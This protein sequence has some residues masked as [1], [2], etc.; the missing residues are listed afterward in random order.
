MAYGILRVKWDNAKRKFDRDWIEVDR[1]GKKYLA[2]TFHEASLLAD[3]LSNNREKLDHDFR[4]K[5]YA[6]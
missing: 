5:E 4:V 3:Q 6:A 1:Y 2:D